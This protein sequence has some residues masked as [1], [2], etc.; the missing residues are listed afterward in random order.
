MALIAP[1]K[2]APYPAAKSWSKRIGVNGDSNSEALFGFTRQIFR[3][4]DLAVKKE[5][6]GYL[7]GVGGFAAAAHF[8]RLVKRKF[9][10]TWAEM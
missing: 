3:R 8:S 6:N 1:I 7:L 9:E 5:M 2:H 4:R 10:K